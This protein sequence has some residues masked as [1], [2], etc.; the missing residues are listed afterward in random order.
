MSET[1]LVGAVACFN[2]AVVDLGSE[3]WRQSRLMQRFIQT[4]PFEKNRQRLTDIIKT[5][6]SI[7]KEN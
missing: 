7:A 2:L 5:I 3:I 6:D 4:D 1:T